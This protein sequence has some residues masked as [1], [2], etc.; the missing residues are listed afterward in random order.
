MVKK[1]F[2]DKPAQVV[3]ETQNGLTGG[4]AFKDYIIHGSTGKSVP[5]DSVVIQEE[6]PWINLSESI[7]GDYDLEDYDKQRKTK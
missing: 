4:I 7:L 3:V 1:N 6:L 5:L 2:F